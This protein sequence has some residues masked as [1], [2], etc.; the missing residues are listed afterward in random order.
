MDDLKAD[1]KPDNFAGKL[2]KAIHDVHAAEKELTEKFR[3][4]RE[5]EVRLN[6]LLSQK[7]N[8]A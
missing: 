6:G 8:I 7:D 5:A 2:A 3:Q 1:P 4:L